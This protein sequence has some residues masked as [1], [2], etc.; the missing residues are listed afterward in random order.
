[1]EHAATLLHVLVFVYWLGG[2][3]GAFAASFVVTDDRQHAS[4]RLAAARLLGH[5]DM[6]PRSAL[7]LALPTGL[8]LALA[9]GWLEL[10]TWMLAA[11]WGLAALWL[12]VLWRLHTQA[13]SQLRLLDYILRAC[14]LA[15]LLAGAWA[16]E[17]LFLKAKLGLL[18]MAVIAGLA[19]RQII[20]PLGPALARLA[21]GDPATADPD[22]SRAL[23]R[24]RPLVI[25]IWGML[26]AAAWLGI[27]KP[28]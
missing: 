16:V 3:L 14:L 4:V 23:R 8:S 17:P 18:A 1:M 21:A 25:C 2:D 15:A 26:V 24:A 20:T 27:S 10:E 6:A 7:V 9:R 12:L 13:T 5:V 19:I 11:T 28:A 22:I